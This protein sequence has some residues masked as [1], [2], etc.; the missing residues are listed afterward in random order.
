MK[1]I[2]LLG[3]MSWKAAITYCQAINEETRIRLGDSHSA[4]LVLRCFDFHDIYGFIVRKDWK[5][6][7][8][9]M[10]EAGR[11][12]ESQGA[13]CIVLCSSTIH[14][15]AEH[16]QEALSIPLLHIADAVGRTAQNAGYNNTGLLGTAVVME[17]GFYAGRLQDKFSVSC[18]IP[19]QSV[20]QEMDRLIFQN[21][22]QDQFTE[23]AKQFY[24]HNME[25]LARY[26]AE[27][28][29]LACPEI[30]MLLLKEKPPVPFLDATKL[31]ALYAVN[32][33]LAT[34]EDDASPNEPA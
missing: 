6:L 16:I 23:Q 18:L 21:R 9:F 13:D 4:D 27:A 24:L 20:R 5:G 25:E 11:D 28:I 33:A 29:I 3:G 22:L 8:T 15:V 10:A 26:G 31:H 12:L 14:Y 2:G 32:F 34:P 19:G 7:G 30:S 1:T 17:M